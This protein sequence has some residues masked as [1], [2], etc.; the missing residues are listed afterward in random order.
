V[1][2]AGRLKLVE[3]A[4]QRA[5]CSNRCPVS[6][7]DSKRFQRA[8]LEA[9]RQLVA[10]KLGIEFPAFALGDHWTFFAEWPS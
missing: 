6:G 8:H 2:S 1:W 10:A 5:R 4:K 7:F 9:F 3:I